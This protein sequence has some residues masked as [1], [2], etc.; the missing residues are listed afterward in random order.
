MLVPPPSSLSLLVSG[1]VL[2]VTAAGGVL[3][4]RVIVIDRINGY[5]IRQA[6]SNTTGFFPI[7]RTGPYRLT[8]TDTNGCRT[9]VESRIDTIP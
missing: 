4:E 5:E 8:V 2:Q 9:S 6:D 7:T 3:F 1:R